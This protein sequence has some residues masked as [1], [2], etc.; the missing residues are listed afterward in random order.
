MVRRDGYSGVAEAAAVIEQR[1][2]LRVVPRRRLAANAAAI[3]VVVIG[4]LM[5]SAVVLHTRLAERQGEID[6]LERQ[7]ESQQEAFDL[8]R[9]QR[10]ELRSPTRLATAA[11]DIGMVP[12]TNADFAT[13]DPWVLAQVLASSGSAAQDDSSMAETD[14]LDQVRRVRAAESGAEPPEF[15]GE[16]IALDADEVQP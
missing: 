16:G 11:N 5:L 13:V 8:L 6:R 15:G 10:A 14:P 7:V 2:Q 1:P 9:Q 4:V 12:A 3:A